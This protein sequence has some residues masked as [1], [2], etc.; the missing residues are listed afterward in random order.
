MKVVRIRYSQCQKV[1]YTISIQMTTK[2]I[3]HDSKVLNG[4]SMRTLQGQRQS[5]FRLTH[6]TRLRHLNIQVLELSRLTGKSWATR[7][8]S[9]VRL[10]FGHYHT[11]RARWAHQGDVWMNKIT[12]GLWIGTQESVDREHTTSQA[13]RK[14]QECVVL[15][16]KEKSFKFQ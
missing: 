9:W 11:Q 4:A 7:I 13:E 2:R 12:Q 5:Q 6:T 8:V 1:S 16:A 15:E 3:K 10:P 14:P